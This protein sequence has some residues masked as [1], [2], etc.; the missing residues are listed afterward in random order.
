MGKILE[1]KNAKVVTEFG[2]V[3]GRAIA[4]RMHSVPQ[5]AEAAGVPYD[6]LIKIMRGARSPNL[7]TVARLASGLGLTVPD[8]L[9]GNF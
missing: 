2:D 5:F 6:T 1:E 7:R 3:L 9:A 8:L 4:S